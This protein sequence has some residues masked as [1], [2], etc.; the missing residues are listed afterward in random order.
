[1]IVYFDTSALLKLYLEEA[2]S[3]DARQLAESATATCTHMITYAEM[4]AALAQAVRMQRITEAQRHEQIESFAADWDAL[5][6]LPVDEPLVKRAGHLAEAFELRGFDS[7]HLAAAERVWRQAPDHFQ[8]A[9]FDKRLADAGDALG[10]ASG[11]SNIG[12]P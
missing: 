3:P 7:I 1:M 6:V 12:N 2:E 11:P 4:C 8:L 9:A 5:Y 10:M